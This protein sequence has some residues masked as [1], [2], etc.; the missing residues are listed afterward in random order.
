VNRACVATSVQAPTSDQSMWH[1]PKRE[2]GLTGLL[3]PTWG[4]RGPRSAQSVCHQ[5][6][7]QPGVSHC[8]APGLMTGP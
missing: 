3:L 5:H 2:P 8:D 7:Q 1:P 4:A 6:V